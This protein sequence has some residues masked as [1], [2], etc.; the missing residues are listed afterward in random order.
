MLIVFNEDIL[1][2]SAWNTLVYSRLS[3]ERRIIM[4]SKSHLHTWGFAHG[5]ITTTIHTHLA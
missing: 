4:E 2:A 3:I 1:Y 5:S